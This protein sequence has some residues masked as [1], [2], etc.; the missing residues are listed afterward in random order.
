[1]K[2]EFKGNKR[3]LPRKT[4]A[5]CG[6]SMTWRKAWARDWDSVRYC[7]DACR[8]KRSAKPTTEPP[9]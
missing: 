9:G 3:S 5:Q 7:S 8:S 6:L 4:C 2:G 1:M